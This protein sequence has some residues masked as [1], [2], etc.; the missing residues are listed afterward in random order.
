LD[1]LAAPFRRRDDV[2]LPGVLLHLIA[3]VR[4]ARSAG[5]GGFGAIR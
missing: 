2:L 3:D 1:G 4:A 5:N